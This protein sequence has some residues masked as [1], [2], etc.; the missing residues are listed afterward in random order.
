MANRYS[1]YISVFPRLL[2]ISD[3]SREITIHIRQSHV[4]KYMDSI[5]EIRILQV[6]GTVVG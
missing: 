4:R 2:R 3:E 6:D 1:K 5:Q